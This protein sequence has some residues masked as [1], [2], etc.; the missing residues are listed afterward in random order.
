MS[1]RRHTVIAYPVMAGDVPCASSAHPETTE[2][3]GGR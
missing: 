1:F 3:M 2:S